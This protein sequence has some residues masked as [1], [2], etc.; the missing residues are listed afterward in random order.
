[1]EPNM[2]MPTRFRSALAC[3]LVWTVW[4]AP[5]AL[6]ATEFDCVTRPSMVLKIGTPVAA[7]LRDVAV[8]RGDRVIKGQILAQLES[9]VEAA[10]VALNAARASATAEVTARAIRL[11]HARTELTRGERLLETST[12]SRQKVDE[13]RSALRV[14]QEDLNQAELNRLVLR[15]ELDRARALLDQRT[16]RSPIDAVVV[17]RALGPGEYAH[18][19]AHIV[20]LAAVSPLHVEA[21]PPVRYF[22]QVKVGDT[23][24]V[25]PNDVA[26]AARSATVSVTDPV[27]DAGSGTFGVRL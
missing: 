8:E 15:L 13:L 10:D 9:A 23:G 1:M 21:Y 5:Q 16:I 25:L 2:P 17:Q 11:E 26:T 27:F 22:G 19:D 20:E 18:Q 4:T 7:T 3:T 12:V 14:A 6:A 24:I